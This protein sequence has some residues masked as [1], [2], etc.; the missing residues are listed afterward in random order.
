MKIKYIK[1]DLDIV[2]VPRND[3]F[4]ASTGIDPYG[5]GQDF[6]WGNDVGVNP[7]G[8]DFDWGN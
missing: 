1:P 6:Q 3:I 4:C 5:N 2:A 7:G 8:G